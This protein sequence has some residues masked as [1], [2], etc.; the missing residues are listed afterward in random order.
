MGNDDWGREG[1]PPRM[2]NRCPVASPVFA[3]FAPLVVRGFQ[4]PRSKRRAS[5]AKAPEVL[6]L[7]R[8]C[9]LFYDRGDFL[10]MDDEGGVAA[11]DLRRLGLDV[12]NVRFYYA[13]TDVEIRSARVF[14]QSAK[15][16]QQQ[17]QAENREF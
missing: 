13:T 4:I 12:R 3:G 10:R 16:L 8:E 15:R 6:L 2:S 1:Q 7:L 17:F 11:S 14:A 9:G 5:R